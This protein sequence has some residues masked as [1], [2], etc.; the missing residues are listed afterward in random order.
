MFEMFL[1][2]REGC[3]ATRAEMWSRS[4]GDEELRKGRMDG[5]PGGRMAWK[6]RAAGF[7]SK[8]EPT[9]GNGRYLRG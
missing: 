4:R 9:F 8:R 5:W 3:V 7:A 2:S 1:S 6:C